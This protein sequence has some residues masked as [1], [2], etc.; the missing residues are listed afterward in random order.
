[1]RKYPDLMKQVMTRNHEKYPEMKNVLKTFTSN[2]DLQSS[3][4]IKGI[5]SHSRPRVGQYGKSQYYNNVF[6]RSSWEVKFA[7]MCDERGIKWQYEPRWF[8]LSNGDRILPDF[9]LPDLSIWIQIKPKRLQD[10]LIGQMKLFTFKYK[11]LDIIEYS[12]F[13]GEVV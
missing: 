7:Q 4:G 1:M 6:M 11:I 2:S 8:T 9:C 3:K 10:K 5:R 12:S 13:F